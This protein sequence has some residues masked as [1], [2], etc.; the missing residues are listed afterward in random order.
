MFCGYTV[1]P[2]RDGFVHRFSF[3]DENG[4][5]L[6]N[7]VGIVFIELTKLS[8]VLKK[9]VEAMSALEMWSVFFAHGSEPKYRDVLNKMTAAKGE[10]KVATELLQNRSKDEIERAHFRSRRMFRMDTEHS[11]AVARD[12]GGKDRA[13]M[14]ARNLFLTG[15]SVE[16]II[17]VTGLSRD[18]IERLRDEN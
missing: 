6:T 18:E 14:L 10:I 13:T 15:L 3:R 16:Q 17:Q 11:L 7:A 9:P 5:E 8:E 2:E 4:I 12:E 1:F